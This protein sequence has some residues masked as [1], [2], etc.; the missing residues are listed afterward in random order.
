MS[1]KQSRVER[2][3]EQKRDFFNQHLDEELPEGYMR[4]VAEKKVRNEDRLMW[5]LYHHFDISQREA[6]DMVDPEVEVSQSTASRV[7]RDMD[8]EILSQDAGFCQVE[9]EEIEPATQLD[10]ST[11]TYLEAYRDVLAEAIVRRQALEKLRRSDAPGWALD[12]YPELANEARH[13]G[14][15]IGLPDD[16][17]PD[18]RDV[19]HDGTVN[20]A[21]DLDD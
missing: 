21:S 8:D 1:K 14:L 17:I 4:D 9:G 15:S 5:A 3:A 19:T 7:L 2:L 12:L 16:E 10:H 18:P 11:E 20:T 13:V 6:L